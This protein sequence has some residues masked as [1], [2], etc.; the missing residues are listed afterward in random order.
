MHGDY[1]WRLIDDGWLRS[2][3]IITEND[4]SLFMMVIIDDLHNYFNFDN[5]HD[6]WLIDWWQ[7]LSWCQKPAGYIGR[8]ASCLLL[9]M[10]N[11]DVLA[12]VNN[13][14]KE[15]ICFTENRI[16]FRTCHNIYK[17]A[18]W[19]LYFRFKIIRFVTKTKVKSTSIKTLFS[20]LIGTHDYHQT[21]SK[22]IKVL[23]VWLC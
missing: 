6:G 18:P 5:Y 13:T 4:L 8:Q 9:G 12:S 2:W 21:I 3:L 7:D 19:K 17:Y 22:H 11:D 16:Y 14:F 15:I 20:K 10:R 23:F 1:G